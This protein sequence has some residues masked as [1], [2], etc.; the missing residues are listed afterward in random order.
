MTWIWLWT[1]T[2]YS[3]GFSSTAR[4]LASVKCGHTLVLRV[5]LFA[6]LSLTRVQQRSAFFSPCSPA[7]RSLLDEHS[8]LMLFSRWSGRN[9]RP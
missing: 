2:V 7:A 1:T 4:A 8:V 5:G 3:N 6:I 9:M